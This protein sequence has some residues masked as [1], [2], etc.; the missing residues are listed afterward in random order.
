MHYHFHGSSDDDGNDADGSA[1]IYL[2]GEK[3]LHTFYVPILLL[4]SIYLKCCK[5]K[6]E[7]KIPP[8]TCKIYDEAAVCCWLLPCAQKKKNGAWKKPSGRYHRKFASEK[9][10]KLICSRLP[11]HLSDTKFTRPPAVRW[12]VFEKW[13]WFL[14]QS[15]NWFRRSVNIFTRPFAHVNTAHNLHCRTRNR[16]RTDNVKRMWEKKKIIEFPQPITQLCVFAWR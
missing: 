13:F 11:H 1:N 3:K 5:K 15:S 14:I 2:K 10:P 16:N 4:R 12:N 7:E 9:V 8:N 6:K